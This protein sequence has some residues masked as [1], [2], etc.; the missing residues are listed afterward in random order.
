VAAAVN[1]DGPGGPRPPASELAS[2]SASVRERELA[3]ENKTLRQEVM[4]LRIE[5]EDLGLLAQDYDTVLEKVLEGLRVYAVSCCCGPGGG[6]QILRQQI[7]RQ[8]IP[9]QQAVPD[10]RT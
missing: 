9:R 5:N 8:Q 2:A 7:L 3:E 1:G 4:D 10:G 6:Q